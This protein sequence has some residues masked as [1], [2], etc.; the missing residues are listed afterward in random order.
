MTK[1]SAKYAKTT[2]IMSI[3]AAKLQKKMITAHSFFQEKVLRCNDNCYLFCN[4]A[5]GNLITNN[6]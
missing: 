2:D 1:S 3:T 5:G 4:F 6:K